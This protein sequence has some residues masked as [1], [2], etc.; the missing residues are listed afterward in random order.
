M[1]DPHYWYGLL[2]AAAGMRQHRYV[3]W[4]Y[5]RMTWIA[6]YFFDKGLEDYGISMEV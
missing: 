5:E 2:V 1:N 4:H 3:K 6:A